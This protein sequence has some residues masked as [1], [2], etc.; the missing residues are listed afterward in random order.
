MKQKGALDYWGQCEII[1]LSKTCRRI[2]SETI[3]LLYSSNTFDFNSIIEVF[4]FSLTILPDRM[5]VMKN[6][7][8][9]YG[10]VYGGVDPSHISP[11]REFPRV[12]RAQEKIWKE[13]PWLECRKPEN[14]S[15]LSCWTPREGFDAREQRWVIYCWLRRLIDEKTEVETPNA[16]ERPKASESLTE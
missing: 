11:R 9:K 16:L 5:R 4:R 6:V 3:E 2:Y 12:F 7:R 8:W 10:N 14:C 1:A 13:K 15:C